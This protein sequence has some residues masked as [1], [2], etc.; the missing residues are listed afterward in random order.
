[1]TTSAPTA[2][3]ALDLLRGRVHTRVFAGMP[4]QV[5]RLR[6]PHDRIAACQRERLRA[7]LGYAMERSPFH[8]RR[9]AGLDPTT[10]EVAD[11]ARIPVMTKAEM[12]AEFGHVVTDARLTRAVVEDALAATRTEPRVLFDDY[13]C[14][15]SGGSTGH[16]GVFVFDVA[17]LAEFISLIMRPAMAARPAGVTL[18]PGGL[19]TAFVAAASPVH[20][21]GCAP[22]IMAGSPIT[23]IP[24]PATLPVREIVDRLNRLQP[25]LLYGY[26]SMIAR[27]AGEQEAGRLRIAPI[28]STEG[29]VGATAPGETTITLGSDGCITEFVDDDNRPVPRGTASAK[30]LV[31][32]LYNRVQP[33][34]RYE[35][36]DSFTRQP[37]DP[38]QGHI[39]ASV[40]GRADEI[41][42]Y[43]SLDIHPLTVRSVLLGA[44]AVSDYQVRQTAR[45]IDVCVQADGVPG[46]GPLRGELTAALARAGLRNPEVTVRAVAALERHPQTGKLRR[47]IP[48]ATGS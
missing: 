2:A 28:A 48:A 32:N 37:D 23:F 43:G 29:L 35:L 38:A 19:S 40:Q 24:V 26:P 33:L 11:L 6:W 44:A 34:I 46:L 14:L 18:P 3:G 16:R 8:A 27:L 21:T 17:A 4:G 45:G 5:Q 36:P 7:L 1:M 20:A 31:T 39:R 22:R 12:M 9:L 42:H 13:L 30:V 41:L 10:F 47:F 15:A 25:P